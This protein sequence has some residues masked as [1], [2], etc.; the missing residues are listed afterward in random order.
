MRLRGPWLI[1]GILLDTSISGQSG[2]I[3]P[4]SAVSVVMNA[5]SFYPAIIHTRLF[6]RMARRVIVNLLGPA[7]A[8][9]PILELFNPIGDTSDYDMEWR[10][11]NP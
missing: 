11:V 10:H 1:R 5:Y 2:I 7:V 3:G 9:N 4:G 6:S 8:D